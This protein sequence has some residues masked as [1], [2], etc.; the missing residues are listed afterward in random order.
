MS[1]ITYVFMEI[2]EK[3]QYFSVEK[4]VLSGTMGLVYR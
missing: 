1:T 2:Y 4:S 3:Y